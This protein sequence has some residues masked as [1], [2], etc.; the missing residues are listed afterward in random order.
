M[1]TI[2]CPFFHH[3]Y[4]L[5]ELNAVLLGELPQRH[6]LASFLGG[7]LEGLDVGGVVVAADKALDDAAGADS[8]LTG[9][10]LDDVASV[11]VDG[12]FEL[13]V[14]ISLG[15]LNLRN[16]LNAISLTQIQTSTNV[17][18]HLRPWRLVDVLKDGHGR[19]L[20]FQ[21][22]DSRKE[23][24][25]RSSLVLD[26]FAMT[27]FQHAEILAGSTRHEHIPLRNRLRPPINIHHRLLLGQLRNIWKQQ[28]ARKVPS[29]VR[30][31]KGFNLA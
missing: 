13:V 20:L 6:N 24:F 11:F 12:E 27:R 15:L 25:T 2:S 1:G 17:F 23:G 22:F 3:Q 21:I 14:G 26:I 18:L 16:I 31:L 7:G 10:L 4:I 8:Y 28:H 19:L 29:N 30:L 5:V 9:Y